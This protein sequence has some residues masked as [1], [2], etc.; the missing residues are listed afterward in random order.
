MSLY[1]S[2]RTAVS[3]MN[4]QSTR[5]ATV[6][7]NI[8]NSG[9]NGYK[10]ASVEF[11]SLVIPNTG[12]SYASG[13]VA[14]TVRYAIASEGVMSY[15]TSVTDLAIQGNGFFVVADSN[16]APNLTRAGSF[17]PDSNGYLVNAAGFRLMGYD[18]GNGIPSPVANGYAGLV[19][20]KLN[21]SSLVAAP[22]TQA[23]LSVNV[24]VNADEKGIAIVD[25]PPSANS[26]Y[27]TYN[28]RISFAHAD[29]LGGIVGDVYFTKLAGNTWEVTVFARDTGT[30]AGFPYALSDPNLTA[31]TTLTLDP[32]TGAI[33]SGDPS[34][35]TCPAVNRSTSIS[36]T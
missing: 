12:T 13:G 10:R 22:S 17:V 35:T 18:Y 9:T 19:P 28:E 30:P 36:L 26:P 2:M 20:V 31:T 27:S 24:P 3:G 1:G 23:I 11:S 15:T 32:V 21:Q 29:P 8:A 16:G 14:T 7:D 6:A 25:V 33:T 5:L 34:L 4:A